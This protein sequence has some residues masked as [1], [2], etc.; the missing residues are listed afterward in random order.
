MEDN[1]ARE[2]RVA[3]DGEKP[4]KGGYPRTIQ[5]EKRL[6]D[7]RRVSSRERQ[8]RSVE[9]VAARSCWK[10]RERGLESVA[11]THISRVIPHRSRKRPGSSGNTGA[12][13]TELCQLTQE[14]VRVTRLRKQSGCA[15][16]LQGRMSHRAVQTGRW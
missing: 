5:S 10:P 3:T 11:G 2:G 12:Q 14:V 6:A 9:G 13:V 1:A 16:S 8:S 15:S 4:L 7:L